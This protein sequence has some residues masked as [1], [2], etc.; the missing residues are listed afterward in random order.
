MDNISINRNMARLNGIDIFYRDTSGTN[1]KNRAAILCLHGRWGRGET[2]V[3]FMLH[4]GDRYCIIAPDQR[5]H[6]LS[7]KPVCKYTAEEM[8]ADMLALLDHLGIEQAIVVGHS[9]GGLNAGWLAANY[10]GRVRAVAILDKSA[11]GP[12][13]PNPTPPAD[14]TASDPETGDWPLPFKSLREA[15]E[16]IREFEGSE[17]SYN[18]FMNSLTETV[19]GYEMMF[20]RPA[21]AAN[22][23]YYQSWFHLLP[24]IT[25]PAMLVRSSSHEGVPDEDWEK[26]QSLLADCSAYEMSHPDHNVFLSNEAEFY[27]YFDQFLSKVETAEQAAS[28]SR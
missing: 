23:A 6:G 12:D 2:W 18:Y 11:N 15:R 21:M 5:G 19:A 17:L 8:G 24:K 10:P 9:M 3:N 26:M 4:Y 13:Q 14:L 25:C 22:I 27:G 28:G 7:G 16:F 1:G 20:S